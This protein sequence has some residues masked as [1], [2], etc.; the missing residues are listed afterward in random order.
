MDVLQNSRLRLKVHFTLSDNDDAKSAIDI[1]Q[2]PVTKGEKPKGYRFFK[3]YLGFGQG[4][5]VIPFYSD[6]SLIQIKS[7]KNKRSIFSPFYPTTL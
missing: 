1:V 5:Y 4:S 2:S 7:V 3:K 6:S